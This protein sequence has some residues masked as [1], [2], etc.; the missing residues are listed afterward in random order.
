MPKAASVPTVKMSLRIPEDLADHYAER[1]SRYGRDAE[2]ELLSRLAAC[3]EHT[4]GSNAIYVDD[5]S[6]Q[7]LNQLAG[8]TIRNADD[9]IQ[10]ASRMTT[11]KVGGV[12]IVLNPQLADRLRSRTFGSTWE[13]HIRSTVIR[14]LEV[15]V[16]LR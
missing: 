16:G 2:T 9:L 11:L 5:Q 15:E 13:D 12:S 1:A 4:D 14:C 7:I 8:Q 10:W 6:R 3:R